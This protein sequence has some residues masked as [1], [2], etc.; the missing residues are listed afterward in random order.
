MRCPF[1]IA[2]VAERATVI[3]SKY[4][5][6]QHKDVREESKKIPEKLCKLV[7]VQTWREIEE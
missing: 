4:T 3:Y 2:E 1:T 6:E 5:T 7:S